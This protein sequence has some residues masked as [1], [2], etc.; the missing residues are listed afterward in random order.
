MAPAG[1]ARALVEEEAVVVVA[2]AVVVVVLDVVVVV[3]ALVVVVAALVVV[4]AAVVPVPARLQTIVWIGTE[5]KQL[6]LP[7]RN[8]KYLGGLNVRYKRTWE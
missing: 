8:C 3:A 5:N 6:N 1:I 4:A 2:F 7:L